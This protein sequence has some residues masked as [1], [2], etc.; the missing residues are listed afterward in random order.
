LK[1]FENFSLVHI[2]EIF[3]GKRYYMKDLPWHY[4]P[5]SILITVPIFVLAGF[6]LVFPMMFVLLKKHKKATVGILLFVM[7]FPVAYII[8]KHAVVY[9]SWRHVLFIYPPMVILSAAGWQALSSV[10]KNNT[11]KLSILAIAA[12]L[13]AKVGLWM[14]KNHPYEYVYYNETVGGVQGA[15]GNYETDYWCQSPKAAVEWLAQNG[16]FVPHK[17]TIIVSNNVSA[18][19]SNY[20]P[21]DMG[22][23]VQV[24]WTREGEW[25]KNYWDYAVFTTRTLTPTQLKNRSFPPKGTIHTID[26]DGIPLAAIVK[27]ENLYSFQ[28]NQFITQN[29]FPQADSVMQKA[30]AYSPESEETWRTLGLAQLN[31]GD[32]VNAEKSIRKSIE[33]MPENSYAY[34]FLG[35]MYRRK[36]DAAN[37]TIAFNE[38]LK[39]R[40]NNNLAYESL[41]DLSA[42]AKDFSAAQKY[43]EKAI[44]YNGNLEQL[45]DKMGRINFTRYTQNPPAGAKFLEDALKYFNGALTKNPKNPNNFYNVAVMLD[46]QGRKEDAKRYFEEYKKMTGK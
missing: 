7:I 41:G 9:S 38:A 17:K 22:D 26:V 33:L 13:V 45:Y 11:L 24:A 40:V 27:R 4:I 10:F 12:V 8:Y 39:F 43:F 20:V 34:T 42:N 35:F 36:N 1:S 46:K 23:S 21:K 28:G 31:R 16:H 2:W 5:K 3:E 32:L 37:A 15:Y 29:K 19:L 6:F 25:E 30:A 18:S 14:V 44:Q